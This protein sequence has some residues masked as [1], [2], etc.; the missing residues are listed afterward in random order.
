MSVEVL[1]ARRAMKRQME[2]TPT[3]LSTSIDL[4]AIFKLLLT[5]SFWLVHEHTG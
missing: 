2:I 3:V 4:F 5:R 1:V